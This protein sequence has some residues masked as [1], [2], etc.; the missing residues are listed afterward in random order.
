MV[1]TLIRHYD[2]IAQP[3]FG[4]LIID[5]FY[6]FLSLD[7]NFKLL[8]Q[9]MLIAIVEQLLETLYLINNHTHKKLKAEQ[10]E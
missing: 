3:E 9:N 1:T 7:T 8:P 5:I 2:P 4:L 10:Q 6:G